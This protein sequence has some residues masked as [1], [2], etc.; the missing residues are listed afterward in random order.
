MTSS[1]TSTKTL[2]RTFWAE[3][4][5]LA[6]VTLLGWLLILNVYNWRYTI[7]V[8]FLWCGWFAMVGTAKLL[9]ASFWLA[10]GTDEEA[11]ARMGEIDESHR[12]DLLRE[13]KSLLRSIKDVEFDRDMGK[14]SEAEAGQILRVY[15]ARAIEI[16]KEL[17]R[18][19]NPIVDDGVSA[20]EA[21]ER[22]L[23]A[24][25]GGATHAAAAARDSAQV[26]EIAEQERRDAPLYMMAGGFFLAGVG[27]FVTLATYEAAAGGGM[28]VMWYG[29]IVTGIA[30]FIR[31][32]YGY[33]QLERPAADER[34]DESK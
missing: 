24:R 32:V 26:R 19:A 5:S 22:E 20:D 4:L 15:R 2:R 6:A 31:G 29:P 16:I 11:D 14:M 18:Y 13:K 33:T 10:A 21:I 34:K 25:L 1:A 9:W 28:Y 7:S 23:A 8:F 17:D 3:Q 12:G 27:V 30:M